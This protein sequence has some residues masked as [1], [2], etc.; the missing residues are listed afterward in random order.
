MNIQAQNDFIYLDDIYFQPYFL[1]SYYPSLDLPSTIV[2]CYMFENK[3][4][5][6]NGNSY[7]QSFGSSVS[8]D[9]V[10]DDSLVVNNTINLLQE[11]SPTTIFTQVN[12]S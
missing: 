11:I 8:N 3:T 5:F 1:V 10:Y 6:E 2:N 9:I 7:I 12:F 4:A